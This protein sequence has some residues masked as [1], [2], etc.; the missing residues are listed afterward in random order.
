MQSLID[1][2][3]NVNHRYGRGDYPL[4][5]AASKGY[6]DVVKILLDNCAYVDCINMYGRSPLH[7]AAKNGWLDVVELL[8]K[9]DADVHLMENSFKMTPQDIA[10]KSGHEDIAEFLK[11]AMTN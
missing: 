7:L 10:L 9:N 1:N 3:A 11:V 5:V 4:H 8:V 6:L 2:S